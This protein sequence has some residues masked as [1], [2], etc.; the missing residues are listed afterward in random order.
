MLGPELG[1]A[2]IATRRAASEKFHSLSLE[3]E[4]AM[5]LNK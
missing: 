1:Q 2:Y 5:A 4:V 3:E